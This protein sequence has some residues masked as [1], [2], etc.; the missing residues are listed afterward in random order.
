MAAGD[1]NSRAVG[2][3]VCT[4]RPDAFQGALFLDHGRDS[5]DPPGKMVGRRP[6]EM[7]NPRCTVAAETG[8]VPECVE[9]VAVATVVAIVVVPW[10][11]DL[12]GVRRCVVRIRL[13]GLFL[14]NKKT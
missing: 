10:P 14:L 3:L 8:E 11:I 7:G 5:L 12:E 2:R 9:C 6:A 13:P 4:P 1:D